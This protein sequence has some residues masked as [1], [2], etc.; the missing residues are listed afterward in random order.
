MLKN[1]HYATKLVFKIR[2][3]ASGAGEEERHVP[4]PEAVWNNGVGISHLV[5]WEEEERRRRTV[6]TDQ[7]RAGSRSPV[8]AQPP[9]P[10]THPPRPAAR[11]SPPC[12]PESPEGGQRPGRVAIAAKTLIYRYF[13]YECVLRVA[14]SSFTGF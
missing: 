1:T 11:A 10:R 6:G 4:S 13:R 2:K 14:L 7:A 9:A 5:S 3:R 12:G 8:R